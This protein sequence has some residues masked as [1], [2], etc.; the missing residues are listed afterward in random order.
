VAVEFARQHP[1]AVERLALVGCPVGK[2]RASERLW[3]IPPADLAGWLDPRSG[4][5]DDLQDCP[6]A[7]P[8]PI[9][10]NRRWVREA[11]GIPWMSGL[12]LPCLLVEGGLD[13]SVRAYTA[14]DRQGWPETV[15]W[16]RLDGC[17]HFP[18]VDDDRFNRLL[19]EFLTLPD[20]ESP[21]A[22]Q[23]KEGWRRRV[24]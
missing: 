7:D 23:V 16:V 10:A 11:G 12:S 4:E 21:R 13:P 17:G 1:G 22:L 18:M 19:V 8:A 3:S 5:K 20:G 14:E 2:M 15:G 6:A 9:E 24:R